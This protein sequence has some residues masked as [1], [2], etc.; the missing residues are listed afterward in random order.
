M[1]Y[2]IKKYWYLFL[3]SIIVNIPLLV[4]STFRT[5]K[6]IITKGGI[7]NFSNI[8]EVEDGYSQTGSFSTIY[9]NDIEGTTLFMNFVASLN[10][11]T[12]EL[13]EKT[14]VQQDMSEKEYFYSGKIQ[15]NSSVYKSI[16]MA[17]TYAMEKYPDSNINI[18]YQ[19]EGYMITYY[20]KTS[21]LKTGDLIK[22]VYDSENNL[23]FSYN[24]ETSYR[25]NFKLSVGDT[26]VIERDGEELS[27]VPEESFSYGYSDY[28]SINNETLS[29]KIKQNYSAVGGPSGG[30][31][32]SLCIYNQLVEK[33]LTHGLKIAGTGTISYNGNVGAIGGIKEKVPTAIDN[34]I[35]VF[36]C[37]SANYEEALKSYN[38]TIGHEKMKLVEIKTFY[39]AVDY[40]EAL[41]E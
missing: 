29:P 31:L 19:F 36:L 38:S 14:T 17:Y 9:V 35:D 7:T 4:F 18:D 1:L 5:N 40:L 22:E 26:I 30:L 41:D 2:L 23:K 34:N 8:I 25:K 6:Y 21:I 39:D 11:N 27:L 13:N 37:V 32:Q 24:D 33:D 20:T 16:I 12:M 3:I 10:P 15:Y 28:Y